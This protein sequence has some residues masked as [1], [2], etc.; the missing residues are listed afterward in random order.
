MK[1]ATLRLPEGLYDDLV[2][3][4]EARDRSFSEY[5][6]MLLRNRSEHAG[7]H[8]DEHDRT[9]P[10]TRPNT[11]EYAGEYASAE[12]VDELEERVKALEA[13]LNQHEGGD[14][15]RVLVND[16]SGG[17]RPDDEP[18]PQGS[19]LHDRLLAFVRE[20]QPVTKSDV[21]EEFRE[22]WERREIKSRSWW[23]RHARPI[24]K[25]SGATH[26]RNKG[27]SFESEE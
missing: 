12:R 22:E 14:G 4:A 3:E 25:G 20:H 13:E 6:R 11:S 23:L 1:T 26:T 2:E 18:E 5:A 10:H 27:W 8:G 19:D 16:E 21:E 24:L 9:Q 7:E 17:E 15:G